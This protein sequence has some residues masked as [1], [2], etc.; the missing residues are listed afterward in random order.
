MFTHEATDNA[1]SPNLLVG[2]IHKVLSVIYNVLQH[3][4]DVNIDALVISASGVYKKVHLVVKQPLF[5]QP[6]QQ[7]V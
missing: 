1:L 7:I 4:V 2:C 3:D 6:V 5:V